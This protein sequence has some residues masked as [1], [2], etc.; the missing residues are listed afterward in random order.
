MAKLVINIG[1][2]AN[3]KSGDPLR[4]AFDKINQN[5]TEVYNTLAVELSAVNQNIIPVA[6]NLY[7]LGSPT[8]RFRHLY[9]APGTIYLGDVKLSNTAGKLTATK[10]INPGE[11]TEYEDPENGDAFSNISGGGRVVSVPASSAGNAGDKAGDLAFNNGYIYYCVANYGAS[12]SE[13]FTVTNVG[14][15]SNAI[16]VN[17]VNNPNYTVPQAG[18]TTVVGGVT[19]TLSAFSGADINGTDFDFLFDVNSGPIPS[20]IILTSNVPYTNI[21]KRVAWSNDTW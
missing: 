10:V 7:D 19:M 12:P 6:D 1:Q 14:E 17:M 16:K 9:V 3:D 11:E 21:W 20:T 4:T 5:F 15:N 18:W 2:T 8:N 13:T